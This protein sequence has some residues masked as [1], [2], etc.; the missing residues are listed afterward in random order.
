MVIKKFK[1]SHPIVLF[2]YFLSVIVLT[3]IQRNCYFVTL[4]AIMAIFIDY[5]YNK[6]NFFRNIKYFLFIVII[7]LFVTPCFFYNGKDILFDVFLLT[8]SKQG[9]IY[10]LFLGLILG[11]LFLWL[12]I[13]KKIMSDNHIIYL[14]GSILPIFGLII[15]VIFNTVK[16]A[17]VQYQKIKEAN[18]HMPVKNKFIYYR[19]IIVILITY[20]FESSLEMMNSMI[21]RGYGKSKRTSF[22]LYVFKKDDALKLVM[23]IL[24]DVICLLG[25]FI[26]Y[27]RYSLVNIGSLDLIDML[28]FVSYL[29]LGLLPVLLG[30]KKNV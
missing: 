26:Y 21:S 27:H 25:Y 2:L 10:G 14:F 20:M 4:M 28:F 18:Y 1:E 23:I 29:L 24:F 15:S 6:N 12:Q 22:Y 13:M 17:K 7:V 11:N 16:K 19:N 30:G 5:I 8:I 9:I 3:L